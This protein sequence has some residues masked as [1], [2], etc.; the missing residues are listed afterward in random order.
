MNANF[1]VKHSNKRIYIN[2]KKQAKSIAKNDEF[3]NPI[4]IQ[5]ATQSNSWD[6]RLIAQG[7]FMGEK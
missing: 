2:F 5:W 3:S 1:C 7:E 4:N 6:S